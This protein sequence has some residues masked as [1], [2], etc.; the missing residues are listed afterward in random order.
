MFDDERVCV[1]LVSGYLTVT[2]P[3]EIA[4]YAQVFNELAAQAVYGP[5]A[6][7]LIDAAIRAL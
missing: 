2:Q 1:E 3:R 4:M 7:A 6:R 5:D